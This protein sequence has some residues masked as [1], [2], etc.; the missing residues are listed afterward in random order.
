MLSVNGA[1]VIVSL[2]QIWL[3]P[4]VTVWHVITHATY[5]FYLHEPETFL[6]GY[7][8][9]SAVIYIVAQWYV[10]DDERIE[11]GWN[12]IVGSYCR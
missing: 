9:L 8:D 7:S 2:S 10:L 4:I 6:T 12:S 11:A 1:L 5:N 3:H